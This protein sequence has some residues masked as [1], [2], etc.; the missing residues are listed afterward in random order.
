VAPTK[1]ASRRLAI[2]VG[3]KLVR[4][5]ARADDIVGGDQGTLDLLSAKLLRHLTLD[6]DDPFWRFMHDVAAD[7][8]SIIQLTPQWM[9]H[10]NQAVGD[11]PQ[12]AYSSV[13]TAAP[14]PLAGG[15]RRLL[16]RRPLGQA[17]A[18][19]LLHELCTSPGPIGC[20]QAAQNMLRQR[21]PF[22]VDERTND[23]I[24][25]TL[26]QPYGELL[27]AVVAD[28]LDI[29]GQF[30]RPG[31]AQSTDWLLS[32]SGFDLPAFVRL[33][34]VVADEIARNAG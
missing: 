11:R 5:A 22:Q 17:G 16:A 19:V 18:Y 7:Q 2:F 34:E 20:P 28:H 1:L 27:D 25:P 6:P 23:G 24:V 9:E 10:F 3:A 14:A 4:L 12:V 29:V 30:R 8:G 15:L 13:L 21:I 31:A 33:W 26:S 32:G